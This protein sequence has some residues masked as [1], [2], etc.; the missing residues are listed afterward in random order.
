MKQESNRKNISGFSLLEILA[1]IAII[2]ILMGIIVAT[3]TMAMGKR[4]EKK[5]E[6]ELEAI[7]M[8][9]EY[10]HTEYNVYPEE[11]LTPDQNSLF[12]S[13]TQ[14]GEKGKKN[15]L[16]NFTGQNDGNGNLVAPV[17]KPDGT[18]GYNYWNYRTG[19]NAEH[20]SG[21]YD[22]WVEYSKGDETIIKGNW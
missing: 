9:I 8:A 20:N 2:A 16:R 17:S 22:L 7:K 1:V 5:I 4:D 15:F 13:L 21:R 12:L 19:K 3:Y 18:D 10:Y 6:S 14:N 11:G